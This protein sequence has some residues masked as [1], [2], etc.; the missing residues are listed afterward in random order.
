MVAGFDNNFF[1][2]KRKSEIIEKNPEYGY[3]RPE[4]YNNNEWLSFI[5][6]MVIGYSSIQ[7]NRIFDSIVYE[8]SNRIGNENVLNKDL[9]NE[10]IAW[11]KNTPTYQR[12]QF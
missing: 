9:F 8:F 10:I 1:N 4:G 6:Y 3:P 5:Y 12:F 2:N 11:I 7:K